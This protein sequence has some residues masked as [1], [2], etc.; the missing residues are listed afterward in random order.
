MNIRLELVSY[1]KDVISRVENF[2]KTFLS[3]N[4]EKPKVSDFSITQV[5]TNCVQ[6]VYTVTLV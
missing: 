5:Q 4:T 2:K 3:T 6:T 1:Q